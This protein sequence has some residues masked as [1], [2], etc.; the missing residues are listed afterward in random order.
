MSSSN[1]RSTQGQGPSTS[2]TSYYDPL[3]SHSRP[4]PS[5][6]RHRP[7]ASNELLNNSNT[8]YGV[9]S[10]PLQ[11]PPAPPVP[12][13]SLLPPPPPTSTS[14]Q[15]RFI[16]HPREQ[17]QFILETPPVASARQSVV[18]PPPPIPS[19]SS[20][21]SSRSHTSQINHH[22]RSGISFE[23]TG[24]AAP[25]FHRTSMTTHMH[26]RPSPSFLTD[27]LQYVSIEKKNE[28]KTQHKKCFLINFLVLVE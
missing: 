6:S 17:R 26:Q 28:T 24:Q 12:P 1:H 19:S 11:P 5:I 4:T 27:L 3:S 8:H 18:P 20:S 7:G 14:A 10:R 23:T 25:L 9:Q 13:A 16:F 21:S 15:T 2:H 22:Q